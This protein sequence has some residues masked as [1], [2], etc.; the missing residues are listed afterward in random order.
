VTGPPQ[1]RTLPR[2]CRWKSS[3]EASSKRYALGV[4]DEV[5]LARR[6]VHLVRPT[7]ARRRSDCP[8][9]LR[10]SGRGRIVRTPSFT[11]RA[12]A[13]NFRPGTGE[14]HLVLGGPFERTPHTARLDPVCSLALRAGQNATTMRAS[15]IPPKLWARWRRKGVSLLRGSTSCRHTV[16]I[17][18]ARVQTRAQ[19]YAE[20]TAIQ[21]V[22]VP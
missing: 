3:H 13:H 6:V 20:R 10:G 18:G 4:T 9:Q 21:P 16:R 7:H 12:R 19:K 17:E 8:S 11:G 22:A 1:G 2:S 5:T 15:M 14:G